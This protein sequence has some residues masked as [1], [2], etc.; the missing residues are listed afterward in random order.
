MHGSDIQ[1]LFINTICIKNCS[2]SRAL[3]S[4]I[5]TSRRKRQWNICTLPNLWFLV[6]ELV[7]VQDAF[8]F[9][10]E[11]GIESPREHRRGSSQEAPQGR[12]TLITARTGHPGRQQHWLSTSLLGPSTRCHWP[13]LPPIKTVAGFLSSSEAG[14]PPMGSFFAPLWR[15]LKFI[16]YL[17]G[18]SLSFLLALCHFTVSDDPLVLQY[19]IS[20]PQCPHSSLNKTTVHPEMSCIIRELFPI[21]FPLCHYSTCPGSG[22]IPLCHSVSWTNSFLFLIN[23]A[24]QSRNSLFPT[25]STPTEKHFS[26]SSLFHKLSWCW[27][28]ILDLPFGRK[29]TPLHDFPCSHNFRTPKLGFLVD[30]LVSGEIKILFATELQSP[31]PLRTAIQAH[32]PC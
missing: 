16:M 26:A 7:V 18:D 6:Q 1:I 22:L 8:P 3:C 15:K 17:H 31:S 27:S 2:P 10:S 32:L 11:Y 14:E 28:C 4:Q 21:P 30:L 12:K 9:P 23:S 29:K 19:T 24:N 25:V 5:L 13:G 20:P